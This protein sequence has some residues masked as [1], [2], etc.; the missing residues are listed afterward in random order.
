MISLILLLVASI[1]ALL[2][3]S[4]ILVWPT[5]CLKNFPVSCSNNFLPPAHLFCQFSLIFNFFIFN[6]TN[7]FSKLLSFFTVKVKSNNFLQ[8]NEE[9]FLILL[10]CYSYTNINKTTLGILL[11]QCILTILDIIKTGQYWISENYSK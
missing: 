11:Y 5:F 7:H 1:L 8:K 4:A 10:I 3:V 2:I 6:T 9:I